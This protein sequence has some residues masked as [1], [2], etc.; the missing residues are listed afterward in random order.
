MF[1]HT[2]SCSVVEGLRALADE[3]AAHDLVNISEFTVDLDIQVVS[4]EAD[5]EQVRIAAV[6]TL[7]GIL[8][9]DHPAGF[10]GGSTLYGTPPERIVRHGIDVAVYT[11]VRSSATPT[12]TE[13]NPS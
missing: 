3:L 5:P 11:A 7:T 13:G 12:T 8:T 10:N 9:P 4:Y 6:D 2:G 1:V